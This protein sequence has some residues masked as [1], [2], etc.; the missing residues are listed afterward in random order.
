[1]DKIRYYICKKR[2]PNDM[3]KNNLYYF[4]LRHYDNN[5]KKFVIEKN[6]VR[7]NYY[8]TLI[9]EKDILSQNEYL[10]Q[11]DFF[12]NYN[13]VRDKKLNPFLKGENNE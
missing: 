1:M 10:D 7:V 8:G 5:N 4:E 13:L 12:K 3:K 6:R 2:V 9:I 11:N